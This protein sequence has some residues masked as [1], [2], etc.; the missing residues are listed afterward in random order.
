MK[1]KELID[2]KDY[3]LI[4]WRIT[5]PYDYEKKDMLFGHCKS[6]N[7]VLISLD[8]DSY[9]EDSEILSYEEWSDGEVINGLTIVEEVEWY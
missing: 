1:I 7:G 2:K 6:E 8:G 5:A 4:E 9:C 3:D